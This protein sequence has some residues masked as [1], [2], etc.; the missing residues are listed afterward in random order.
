MNFVSGAKGQAQLVEV[1]ACVHACVGRL[2]GCLVR[3]TGAGGGRAL[4]CRN[5]L[6]LLL[7]LLLLLQ[8]LGADVL[9]AEY[10]GTAALTPIEEAARRLPQWQQQRQEQRKQQLQRERKSALPAQV[11]ASS[12]DVET[13]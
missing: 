7:L 5:V 8:E 4:V 6:L 2:V 12:L 9:P 11:E 1:R 3:G 13:D 10:G